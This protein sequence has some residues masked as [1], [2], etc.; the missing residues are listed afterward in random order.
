VA[1]GAKLA[2]GCGHHV[3]AASAA[4]DLEQVNGPVEHGCCLLDVALVDVGEGQ[5]S[6][7]DCLGLVT[8]LEALSTEG[9]EPAAGANPLGYLVPACR[10]P[11]E[12]LPT[13][14]RSPRTSLTPRSS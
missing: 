8:A 4:G 9:G 3:Q 1:P 10:Q 7:D 5:V 12:I 2:D 13:M 14:Q 11:F 6:Q